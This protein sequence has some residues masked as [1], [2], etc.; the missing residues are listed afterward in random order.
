MVHVKLSVATLFGFNLDVSLNPS[1]DVSQSLT[2]FS[3]A[4]SFLIGMFAEFLRPD[5]QCRRQKKSN[6][7]CQNKSGKHKD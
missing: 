1:Q 6:Y 4:N 7:C 5:G 2:R 3:R